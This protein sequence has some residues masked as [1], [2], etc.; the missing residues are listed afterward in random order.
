[1]PCPIVLRA[2]TTDDQ[3]GEVGSV[4]YSL[5]GRP[6]MDRHGKPSV[7]RNGRHF[8]VRGALQASSRPRSRWAFKQ[9]TAKSLGYFDGFW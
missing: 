8:E 5:A 7:S 2:A 6:A 9:E 3:A 1:M 4:L